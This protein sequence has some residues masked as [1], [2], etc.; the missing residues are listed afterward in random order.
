MR[1]RSIR[2]LAV[3]E[4][5]LGILA[6]STFAEPALPA[7]DTTSRARTFCADWLGQSEP[8]KHARLLAAEQRERDGR[9]DP[10]CRAA[11]R[12][13]LRHTLDA[14]CRNWLK[15]MDFEVRHVVERV[16]RPC[17]VPDNLGG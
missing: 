15:L 5:T 8:A 6:C 2:W 12:G 9:F 4:L 11:T 17:L 1:G 3:A 14:E 10:G 13:A 7:P 16:L